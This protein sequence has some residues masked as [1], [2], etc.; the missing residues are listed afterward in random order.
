MN[1]TW[2]YS[3]K[4]A[5]LGLD[6]CDLDRGDLTW[7]FCMDFTSVNCDNSWTFRND[8]NTVKKVW[9]TDGH[10]DGQTVRQT[11][12]VPRSA[13]S[14]L[15]IW[16]YSHHYTLTNCGLMA[17]YRETLI[18]IAVCCLTAVSNYLLTS[19]AFTSEQFQ[20]ECPC[21]HVIQRWISK[22]EIRMALT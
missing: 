5:K 8:R 14:Q 13:W 1:L 17:P 10:T 12:S 19:F 22:Y 16:W 2:S 18:Q 15:N 20:S 3:P 6:L 4:T 7:T 21:E 11:V 9:R